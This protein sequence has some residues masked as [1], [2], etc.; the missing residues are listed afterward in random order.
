HPEGGD[1][2]AVTLADGVWSCEVTEPNTSTVCHPKYE[3]AAAP[4]PSGELSPETGMELYDQADF[5]LGCHVYINSDHSFSITYDYTE[6][7]QG[8]ESA[9]GTWERISD[10]ELA[11][12]PESGDDIAVTLADGVWSCEV[13]EP[14]T[15]TVCRPKSE[16]AAEPVETAAEEK[17]Y[18]IV[19]TEAD[20][21]YYGAVETTDSSFVP[22]TEIP[23][24]EGYLFAGWQ[25]RPDVTKADLV[26]GVSPYEVPT[27]ASSLY[28]G[29]GVEFTGLE[30][31]AGDMLLLYPRWV[32]KTEIH[33]ADELKNMAE[34][35]CGW[36]ELA[37]DIDLGGEKWT[38]VGKYFSNYETVNAPYWTYA[39]RG[40]LDG[41]GHTI[42]GLY[43]EGCEVDAEGYDA[44]AAVWRDDGVSN[45]GEAALFG[46]IA[47]ASIENL[48]I[49]KPVITVA[50]DNDA[51]PYVAVV[52]GFDLGSSIRNVTVNEPAVSVTVS[53]RNAVSR[54]SAWAAV[55]A[56]V[57]GG[58]SDTIEN[59][60]VNGAVIAVNGTAAKSHGG[61]YYVGSMLGEGYAFMNGNTATA[62][63]SIT[64]EDSS[65][66]L[67]DAE[68]IVNVGGMGG[69][70]T[71]QSNGAYDTKISVAV[72]K[73]VG[74]AAVSI[75]GLTGSQRYSVAENNTIKAEISTDCRLD[76]EAGKLYV[77]SVI[78]STNVPYCIVQMI[79]AAPG[80]AAASGCRHNDADVT[81]NGEAV[82][83]SKGETLTVGGEELTYIANGDVTVDGVTYASNINDVITAYGSAVP[84][85]FLQSCVILLI[86]D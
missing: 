70:N 60:T 37:A 1:D 21:S 31:F 59:C 15:S 41:A 46:A 19:Y 42:S 3:V 52:A 74:A 34:D 81:L 2:I 58:W 57:G 77:G 33:S 66:A 65:T 84:A 36:Y 72:N 63:I 13:T 80:S 44:S 32:E 11:L 53:D 47:R 62:E 6:D 24:R 40:T 35:L 79:F 5:W 39:F 67:Q 29:A 17:T 9:K 48:V 76:P 51:T 7:A 26:L 54:A 45:G 10:T 4:A 56:F 61:E 75:G 14:N 27:G 8:I 71:D 30:S 82:T 68:L 38:P 78:G 49:E 23:T 55:S 64:V 69:T 25:T 43:I 22:E 85:A 16:R 28:G 86:S 20:G 12:H 73:P 18:M 50:S 83:A